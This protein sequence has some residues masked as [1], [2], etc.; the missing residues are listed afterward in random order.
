MPDGACIYTAPSGHPP[1]TA[2]INVFQDAAWLERCI[3]SLEGKV[4][5][6]VVVDGAYEK[7][8]HEKPWSTDG[9]LDIAKAKADVV[10]TRQTVWPTETDKRNH[11]IRYVPEGEWWLRIDADEELVG[12]FYTPFEGVCH[13]L[14]LDRTDGAQSYPI[15][16]LFRRGGHSRYYGC[17]H[18]VWYGQTLLTKDEGVPVYPGVRLLHHHSERSRERQLAK[19]KGYYPVIKEIECGFRARFKV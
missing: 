6:I 12:S 3:A 5:A 2:C 18:A 14:M 10:V 8:P 17:H 9:T 11:Y 13:Q 15:H 19:G 4:K 1:V 7:F 16:A